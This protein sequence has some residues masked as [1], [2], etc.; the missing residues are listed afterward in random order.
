MIKVILFDLDGTLYK[1]PEVR[2]K[3]AEAAYHALAKLKKIPVKKAK[4]LI[5]DRREELKK[6][7]GFPVPYTLTLVQ[8]GMPVEMWHK[9]NIDFFDPRDYLTQNGELKEMLLGLRKR[10]RLAI[11]TNN[12][13]VQ[14]QRILEA[15]K[16]R[17]LFARV[18]SYNSFKTMKPNP[19]FFKKAAKEMDVNPNECLVVGDRYSVDLIPAQNLGMKIYEVKGP[20]DIK[21]LITALLSVA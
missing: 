6:K 4:S 18:F 19:Q 5:E 7:H 3:F 12:N 17:D 9:E 2:K 8:F 10:C 20:D 1:S 21:K 13:E 15:L 11:L 14:A 16:V